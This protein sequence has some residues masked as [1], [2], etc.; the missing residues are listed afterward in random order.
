MFKQYVRVASVGLVL[1][2]VH[3][4]RLEAYESGEA[5]EP[6]SNPSNIAS[7]SLYKSLTFIICW[8]LAISILRIIVIVSAK[9]LVCSNDCL[10]KLKD[11]LYQSSAD[12]YRR[13]RPRGIRRRPSADS[14]F[15]LGS[16]RSLLF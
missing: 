13:R 15:S 3:A 1:H 4:D 6:E 10:T 12:G 2:K 9:I 7:A 5:Y 8:L 11:R 14:F 16:V